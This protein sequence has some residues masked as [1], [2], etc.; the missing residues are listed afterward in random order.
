MENKKLRTVIGTP[1]GGRIFNVLAQIIIRLLDFDF[2]AKDAIAAPR[3]STRLSSGGLQMEG[4]FPD[5]TCNYLENMGYT[6]TIMEEFSS[7][8]GGVQLIVY[9][10]SLD[11]YIGVSD[12]R[13]DG[14][15]LGY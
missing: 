9:D 14:G 5:A 12:S 8:F 1:G 3:F 15:A 2:A 7:Y 13:R 11:K 10:K 4:R 6:L